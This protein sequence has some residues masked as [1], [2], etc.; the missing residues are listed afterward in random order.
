MIFGKHPDR[1]HESARF[2]IFVVGVLI[3]VSSYSL[4]IG[5]SKPLS[6]EETLA[7][8][9]KGPTLGS[10][11]APVTMVEFAD[12]QCSFCRKFWAD[13]FPKLKETHIKQGRVRIIYRHFAIL[14]KFSEQ[15]AMAA[16]CA[17]EQGKFWEYHDQLFA[18]QGGLA[19][20][21]SKL[22]QYA[23]QIRLKPESFDGCLA[24]EKYRKKVEGET[25]VAASLGARGTPTFFV[26]GR[27]M[28]GAQ[29]FEVFQAVIE[30][31]LGQGTSK[32]K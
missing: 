31:E 8:L 9:G 15:A 25:A 19:F 5:A 30:E 2:I 17:G 32:K 20:T 23:R 22:K 14:G 12:F 28:V 3:A 24:G 11:G 26:N 1:R 7:A 18:N 4:A 29:P 13:T 21:Q 6:I 27:L 10:V 16:E